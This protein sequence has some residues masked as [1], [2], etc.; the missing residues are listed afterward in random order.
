MKRMKR[1]VVVGYYGYYNS[2]D[3]AILTSICSDIKAIDSKAKITVLSNNPEATAHE[4]QVDAV[5]RFNFTQVT[6]VI[7]EADIL[8]LGGGS[9]LQDRTS[10]RS[11]YYYLFVVWY[12]LRKKKKVLLYANGIGPIRKPLNR[13]ATRLV[14]NRVDAITLREH[15]S[16]VQLD[17][18]GIRK[19]WVEVTADPVYALPIKAVDVSKVFEDEGIEM[20][21]PYVA[22]LFRSW[23]R[24]DAYVRKM[25]KILDIISQE[26]DLDILLVPMKYPADLIVSGEINKHMKEKAYLLEEKYD[27]QTLIG[28]LG[29]ARF[30]MGM[31]LHG[32]LYASLM[33]KPMIGFSYDPKIAY[34]L[35]ELKMPNAGRIEHFHVDEVAAQADH[36]LAHYDDY[37]ATLEKQVSLLKEKAALNKALLERFI[38]NQP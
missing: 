10:T 36:L 20:A 31:R 8:L 34:Y 1:I 25:A 2:G 4:Y 7:R 18:M 9:L 32:L 33:H 26:H 23:H 17:K 15:L 24:E 13:L 6:Q 30:V 37:V 38:K 14:V 16:K 3:D 19:P 22:V 5:Y 12:A 21:R 29:G 28:I 11:L 27:V 35:E